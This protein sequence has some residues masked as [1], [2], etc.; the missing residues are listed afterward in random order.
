MLL[1]L[2]WNLVSCFIILSSFSLIVM[3]KSHEQ[4]QKLQ[5]NLYRVTAE[6]LTELTAEYCA[7]AGR[8][9]AVC[10]NTYELQLCKWRLA[11]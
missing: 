6:Q 4:T 7:R 2:S 1:N 3:V 8:N 10:K 11:K 9:L 5:L